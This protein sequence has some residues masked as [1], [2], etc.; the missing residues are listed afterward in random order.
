MEQC[1]GFEDPHF[2]NH[3]M[4]LKKVLYGLKKALC[5]WY[6]FMRGGGDKALF[7][8]KNRGE[9]MVSQVYMDDIIFG[10]TKDGLAQK[11]VVTMQSEFEMSLVRELK[12]FLRFQVKQIKDEISLSQAKYAKE[13]IKK[14]GLENT[15]PTQTFMITTLKL[16]QDPSAK[17][18]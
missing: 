6:S 2:P 15:N 5:T 16:Y 10:S 4:R 9:V 14:F 8:S 13:L 17:K 7:V 11:F 18:V 12:F 3:V 1:K